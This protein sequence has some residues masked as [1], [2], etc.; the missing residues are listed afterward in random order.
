MAAVCA[1]EAYAER[2]AA[3]P[4]N[5]AR[6]MDMEPECFIAVLT[7]WRA[8]FTARADLPVM[9]VSEA[10]LGSIAVP[11]IVIPGNDLTHSSQSASPPSA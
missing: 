3:N 8:L 7:R 5:R 10:E 4:G 9:G 2:I 6:L 11:A 1:T